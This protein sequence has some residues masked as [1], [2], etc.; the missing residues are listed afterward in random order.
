MAQFVLTIKTDNAAFA[1]GME[2][3]EVSR[4]L[5]QAADRIESADVLYPYETPLHDVNGNRVGAYV[6]TDD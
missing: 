3:R 6:L 5:A 2:A 1:D 4:I